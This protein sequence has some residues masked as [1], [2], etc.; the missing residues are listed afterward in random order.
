MLNLECWAQ[1]QWPTISF[2]DPR[3]SKRAVNIAVEILKQPMNSLPGRFSLQ[4]DVKGCYCF[5][6]NKAIRHQ[7]LQRQHYENVLKEA[8]SVPGRVLFIQDGSELIYNNLNM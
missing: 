2:F 6:S 7:M 8:A 1:E 5:L 4:K 3:L